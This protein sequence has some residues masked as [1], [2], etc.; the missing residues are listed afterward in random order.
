MMINQIGM[1]VSTPK[2]TQP[3]VQATAGNHVGAVD[4]AKSFGEFLND[5]LNSVNTQ[6]AEAEQLTHQ[7]ISGQ[8]TDVH[9]VTIA[10]EK[11]ALALEL[12]VQVRNKVVEA[13][14]EVMRIQI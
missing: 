6:R 4:V 11:A 13:Y 9:S 10:A 1:Q 2:L 8:I 5:A 7:F 14:Q 12:T 3:N